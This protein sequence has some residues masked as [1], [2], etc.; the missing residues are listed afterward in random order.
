MKQFQRIISF[1]LAFVLVL[2]SFPVTAFAEET[3]E[4]TAVLTEEPAGETTEE[5]TGEPTEE[6]TESTTMPEEKPDVPET[7]EAVTEPEVLVES[8]A[9]AEQE[10]AMAETHSHPLCGS[11]CSCDSAHSN[12]EWTAWNGTSILYNG[13]YYLTQDVVLDSTTVLNNNY[14]SR[15]V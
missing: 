1:L 6:P 4:E 10:A 3:E 2:G 13:N 11:S 5:S 7:S 9:Y 8:P 14:V 12:T 15:C